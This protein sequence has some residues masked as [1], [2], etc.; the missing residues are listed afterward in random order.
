MHV[1]PLA[2][3]PATAAAARANDPAWKTAKAF[4]GMM[5]SQMLEAM[6]AGLSTD[7]PFGGG[8]AEETYRGLLLENYGSAMAGGNGAGTGIAEAVYAQINAYRQAKES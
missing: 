2:A 7:G 3:T 4:E 1:S 8:F 5:M 6:F